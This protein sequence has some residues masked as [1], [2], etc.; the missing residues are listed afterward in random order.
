MNVLL[1]FAL[2]AA[3]R[4]EPGAARKPLPWLALAAFYAALIAFIAEVLGG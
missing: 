4:P 2:S 3:H 1:A